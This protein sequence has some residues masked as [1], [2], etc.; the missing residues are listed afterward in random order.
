MFFGLMTSLTMAQS[1]E[2]TGRVMDKEYNDV[3]PFA[4][5]LIKETGTGTTT[6]FE[7]AY[8]LQLE[9]GVYTVVFSFIGYE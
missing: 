9:P 5:V 7:G 8:S 4:N 2:L 6:D 1:G 3:L